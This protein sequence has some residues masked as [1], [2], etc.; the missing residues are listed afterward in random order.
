M[1]LDTL[2]KHTS[3]SLYL[4]VQMLPASM[5]P[6]FGIA[7]LL[8][9]YADTIADTHL[10]PAEKRLYAIQHFAQG[11]RTRNI[12]SYPQ[13]IKD[14]NGTSENPYEA[15]LLKHLPDCL[16]ALDYIEL[17]QQSFIYDV[18]Q[19]VCEGMYIDLSTFENAPPHNPGAFQ[20]IKELEHYCRLMG[21]KPG[22][23]WSQLI[24][25]TQRV[26][27]P[28]EPFFDLGQHIGDAL[29]IVNV[30]RDLPK[31]LQFGRCYFPAEQLSQY[32]LTPRDLLAPQN[33]AKFE[34][35]KR[36]WLHWGK[37]NLQQALAYY[38]ALPK[39]ALRTRAAVAWPILWT[40]DTFNKLANEPDLL[41]PAKRVKIPR[42][43]IYCTMCATPLILFGSTLFDVWLTRK[44]KNLP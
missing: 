17:E 22:L 43:R 38:R 44:L 13:L 14:L 5:R 42:S 35:I 10:L 23:F 15:E 31:D 18:V 33:A 30:L 28:K 16:V 12:S 21:G 2:L 4:S 26:K 37:K 36:Y 24:F 25:H 8:C 32:G 9:R 11:I 29:Q 27:L 3:R 34:P 41:N 20:T 6:A 39:T 7:Y 1:D 40:A 19:A